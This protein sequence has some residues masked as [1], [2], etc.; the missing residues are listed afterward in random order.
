MPVSSIAF[1]TL[2]ISISVVVF[3][4]LAHKSALLISGSLWCKLITAVLIP[5][6]LKFKPSILDFGNFILASPSYANLSIL[7]PPG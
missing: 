1:F 4:K 5:L 2:S 7:G 6:K 3:S